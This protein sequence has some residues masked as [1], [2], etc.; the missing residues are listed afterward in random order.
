MGGEILKVY[1]GI[2]AGGIGSRM[3]TRDGLPKQFLKVGGIPVIVRTLR[4]FFECPGLE[5]IVIAMHR[6]WREYAQTLFAGYEINV[7]DVVMIDGGATRFESLVNLAKACVADAEDAGE[8]GEILMIN[9]DCARPFVTVDILKANV[10]AVSRYDMATTSVPTI[11][12]VLLSKDGMT[13]DSVPDRSTVFCDQGPQTIRVRHFLSLV[14]KIPLV[15]RSR[16]IE[17]G[18]VYLERGFKVG[19]VAGD[20]NNFKLTTP[21]DMAVAE[22]LLQRGMVR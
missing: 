20:R 5:R 22:Q 19:I 3:A 2:L 6:D 4:R 7:G 11:D 21:F 10:S 17:A 14:A 12:T 16:Y 8:N 9:H 13:S 18:R 1:G 15:E